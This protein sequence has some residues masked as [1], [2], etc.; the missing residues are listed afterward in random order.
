MF[1]FI[2]LKVSRAGHHMMLLSSAHFV[3]FNPGRP[4]FIL[5]H[6]RIPNKKH[7]NFP[8]SS[9]RV[10]L[11]S[12]AAVCNWEGICLHMLLSALD[13]A[14]G[15]CVCVFINA[16]SGTS[17]RTYEQCTDFRQWSTAGG[18]LALLP[19]QQ[20]N[21]VARKLGQCCL[22]PHGGRLLLCALD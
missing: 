12:K 11:Q 20:H 2:R 7:V 10:G 19:T 4:I 16:S 15:V 14:N 8:T 18:G 22:A 17:K 13:G 6:T 21:Y 1:I 3:R 9:V 5:P